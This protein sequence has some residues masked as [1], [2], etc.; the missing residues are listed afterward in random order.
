MGLRHSK[1]YH[2]CLN[3]EHNPQDFCNCPICPLPWKDCPSPVVVQPPKYPKFP[4][5]PCTITCDTRHLIVIICVLSFACCFLLLTIIYFR[6]VFL[7]EKIKRSRLQVQM[8]R[9]YGA[10]QENSIAPTY[11]N[12]R[13]PRQYRSCLRTTCGSKSLPQR[14]T[15]F[16][17]VQIHHEASNSD[18]QGCDAGSEVD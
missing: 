13:V 5:Q 7:Q 17:T 12:H 14:S 18:T 1:N 2:A 15:T 3:L 9:L 8:C 10:R 16:S 4:F 6:H 11:V